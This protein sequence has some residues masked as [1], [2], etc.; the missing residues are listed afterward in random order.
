MKIVSKVVAGALLA[1]LG[2]SAAYA[3]DFSGPRI[4]AHVGWDKVGLDASYDDGVDTFSVDGSKSGVMYGI[5]IGYDHQVSSVILG[6]EANFDMADTKRCSEVFGLDRACLKA[7]RD[8]EVA[9]RAG[10]LINPNMLFYVKGGYVNGK[11]KATYEDFEDILPSFSDSDTR[12]GIRAGAGVEVKTA[13]KAY[14]KLEYRYTDYKDWKLSDP[15]LGDIEAGFDRHQ[16][17]AGV[18]YRF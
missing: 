6:L 7:K 9:V 12:S 15:D 4:E 10:G 16:I 14:L 11:V 3:Q 5:G 2:T 17:V 8:I 18:G 1:G 13:S